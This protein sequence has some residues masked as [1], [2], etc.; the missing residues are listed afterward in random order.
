MPVLFFILLIILIATVGFWKT[1]GAIVGAVAM[2]VL[3]VILIA[4]V[5]AI[6]GIIA[7]KRLR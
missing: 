1:L 4:A 3:L 6:G 5:A 2:V 7:V